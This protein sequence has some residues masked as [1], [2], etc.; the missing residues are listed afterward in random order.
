MQTEVLLLLRCAPRLSQFGWQSSSLSDHRDLRGCSDLK[1]RNS[2]CSFS[3]A[4]SCLS[5]TRRQAKSGGIACADQ[6]FG[7]AATCINYAM[8]ASTGR[9]CR[10]CT[11][12][13]PSG[14]SPGRQGHSSVAGDIRPPP[15]GQSNWPQ[16]EQ[17][18]TFWDDHLD[19]E[20]CSNVQRLIDS[21]VQ[22]YD[23]RITRGKSN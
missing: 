10:P 17:V 5:N 18:G 19:V 11:P 8:Q 22:N 7:F 4:G 12:C 20:N 6:V 2:K 3:K 14:T 16:G 15:H 23:L 21:A 9:P 1:G 13:R